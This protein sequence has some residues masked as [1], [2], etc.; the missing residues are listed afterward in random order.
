VTP[1]SIPAPSVRRTAFALAP[2]VLL[3][4]FAGGIAFP[5]LPIIGERQGLR[6]AFIG[7]IL[8]ANRATRVLSMPLVG[9]AVDRFGGRRTLVVGLSLQILVML[10][11][12]LGI[13]P[14]HAGAFFLVGRILHGPASGCVFV[15]G[16]ALALHAGGRERAGTAGSLV[17]AAMA[18]GVPVGIVC[19]GFLAEWIGDR[20][21]F[22]VAAAAVTLGAIAAWLWVPDLRPKIDAVLAGGVARR[23]PRMLD[24]L[25]SLAQKPLAAIG[26]LNFASNFSAQGMVLSTLVLMVEERHLSLFEMG[27]RATASS[28]MGWMLI[29]ESAAMPTMGRQGDLRHAHAWFGVGGLA[30]LSLGLTVVGLATGNVGLGVGLACIGLGTGALGPSLLALLPRWVPAGRQGVGVSALQLCGD[31]GGALG[32]LVGTALLSGSVKAPYLVTAAMVAC[33][34]PVGGWLAKRERET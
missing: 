4:G 25:R 9:A 33:L 22:E 6:L 11:Y 5:I 19:G 32:P 14:G 1:E 17:R 31:T 12:R 16:Q 2:A 30:S 15:S 3:A 24:A 34:L 28:L 13:E 18:V 20:A 7:V 8:A 27:P 23:P 26:A 10:F 21:T 29:V